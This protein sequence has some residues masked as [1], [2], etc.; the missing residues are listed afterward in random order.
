[1]H[2]I[3]KSNIFPF[4]SHRLDSHS[5][6]HL[7][8]QLKFQIL[9]NILSLTSYVLPREGH[10]LKYIFF[11]WSISIFRVNQNGF[12]FCC[13]FV[14]NH[15]SWLLHVKLVKSLFCFCSFAS[16][17]LSLCIKFLFFCAFSILLAIHLLEQFVF[18]KLSKTHCG[19][20]DFS[21]CTL[22]F[23]FNQ[24]MNFKLFY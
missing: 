5:S 12:V 8:F 3:Q 19:T 24:D 1:M 13:N 23:F 11:S 21:K 2:L 15:W 16:F 4:N 6:M 18:H 20:S 10:I 14:G 22:I 9:C 17:G 7:F